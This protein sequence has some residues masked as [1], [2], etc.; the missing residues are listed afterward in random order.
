M[1]ISHEQ[2]T[3]F[4]GIEHRCFPLDDMWHGPCSLLGAMVADEEVSDMLNNRTYDMLNQDELEDAERRTFARVS[5]Q[6]RALGHRNVWTLCVLHL[7]PKGIE[8]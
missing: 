1:T 7:H 6:V 8:S 5:H 3:H 2:R 4:D